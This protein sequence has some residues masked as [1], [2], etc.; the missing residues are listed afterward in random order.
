[1]DVASQVHEIG[2]RC[3]SGGS[4]VRLIGAKRKNETRHGNGVYVLTYEA[5]DE[6]TAEGLV[7]LVRCLEL[8]L[9]LLMSALGKYRPADLDGAD[10]WSATDEA[11]T[12]EAE[13]KG[14]GHQAPLF[15]RGGDWL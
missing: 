15:A 4:S 7:R 13:E 1:M 14:V 10:L 6:D 5:A 12:A 11:A 2:V 3:G 8:E 9:R